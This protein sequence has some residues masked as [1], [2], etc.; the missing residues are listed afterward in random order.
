MD[1]C[2][3]CGAYF[4]DAATQVCGQCGQV[5]RPAEGMQGWATQTSGAPYLGA[6]DQGTDSPWPAVAPVNHQPAWNTAGP[7][8]GTDN[9]RTQTAMISL[10]VIGVVGAALTA[11]LTLKPSSADAD[12]LI[13]R[14]TSSP[15]TATQ[16]ASTTAPPA[17]T[18]QAPA[19]DTTVEQ[20]ELGAFVPVLASS[21]SARSEVVTEVGRLENC[22][23][24]PAVG[25]T[26]LDDAA[27]SRHASAA[28]I[29]QW[30]VH[31]IPNGTVLKT[32]LVALLNSSATADEGY[33]QWME[34]IETGGCSVVADTD[35]G[36]QAGTA[37]S[38][39]ATA[40][41]Q[42]FLGLWNPLA[43]QFGLPSYT[44]DQL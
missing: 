5:R 37:A 41:K 34:D 22:Q 8:R 28:A 32:D 27:N 6:P 42:A 15:A 13:G 44:Q 7:P 30:D 36:F 12:N 11:W 29:T 21:V 9:R 16:P 23:G 4:G 35:P 43:A 3:A 31:A 26:D 14:S 18:A 25:M 10:A 38:Q 40:N 19:P 2:T 33:A 20:Q 17:P 1:I 39:G 24:D